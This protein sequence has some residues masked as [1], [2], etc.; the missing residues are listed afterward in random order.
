MD[1]IQLVLLCSPVRLRAAYTLAMPFFSISEVWMSVQRKYRYMQQVKYLSL[2]VNTADYPEALQGSHDNFQA[3]P[4]ESLVGPCSLKLT[5]AALQEWPNCHPN[6]PSLFLM[7]R[8]EVESGT[9]LL[10]IH[11]MNQTKN[12]ISSLPMHMAGIW[13]RAFW[14]EPTAAIVERIRPIVS[15]HWQGDSL[16]VSGLGAAGKRNRPLFLT[17][18]GIELGGSGMDSASRHLLYGTGRSLPRE[19]YNFGL[20]MLAHWHWAWGGEGGC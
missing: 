3:P 10:Y 20:Q 7:P 15:S 4:R 6:S 14:S 9:A 13:F 1:G 17:C 8:E 5:G 18:M 19:L 2:E 12:A 16:G 11:H